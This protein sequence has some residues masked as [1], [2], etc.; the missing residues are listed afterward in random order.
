MTSIIPLWGSFRTIVDLSILSKYID[1]RKGPLIL[2][3][4]I[5]WFLNL[6]MLY[7]YLACGKMNVQSVV[8]L[9]GDV[10]KDLSSNLSPT[11][12]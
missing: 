6:F 1:V 3:M 7:E 8:V 11:F 12:S 9:Y 4:M 2:V 5:Q 10:G